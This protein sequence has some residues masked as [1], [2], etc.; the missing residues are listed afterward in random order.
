ME[1]SMKQME[2]NLKK[3]F[4]NLC[5]SF[6][7]ILIGAPLI[8]S[9]EQRS[10]IQD[11]RVHVEAEPEKSIASTDAGPIDFGLVASLEEIPGLFLH[12]KDCEEKG[13]V[14]LLDNG[15]KWS[16]SEIEMV[17]NWD[18]EDELLITQN[19]A[20][21]SSI[22]ERFAIVN[23][24]LQKAVPISRCSEPEPNEKAMY[25]KKVD[26]KNNLLVLNNGM[27][28]RI[29]D[30]DHNALHQFDENDRIL[31]GF[32]SGHRPNAN[33]AEHFM[34]YIL[35]NTRSNNYVRAVPVK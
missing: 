28:F 20:L 8:G 7:P 32:N 6:L 15:S 21:F 30:H 10:V 2:K 34:H 9:A 25:V 13:S 26:T 1:S 14:F 12:L 35:V 33:F 3:G 19:E 31:I 23:R 16:T 5:F 4:K 29:H 27:E 24:R 22:F 11:Y 18:E 17:R